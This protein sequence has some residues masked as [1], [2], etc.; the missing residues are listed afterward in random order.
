MRGNLF[1]VAPFEQLKNQS[2]R[3]AQYFTYI[4][5]VLVLVLEIT[6]ARPL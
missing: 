4:V 6:L 3:S 2:V 5:L 1:K